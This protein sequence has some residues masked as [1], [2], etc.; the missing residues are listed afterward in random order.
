MNQ[1][2]ILTLSRLPA[3]LDTSQAAALLGFAEH[4]V[5]ILVGA[6]LLK[7]LGNP[8]P[9]GHKYFSSAE[10]QILTADQAWLHKATK[11]VTEHW[12]KKNERQRPTHDHAA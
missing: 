12:R 8:P 3:R 4:D 2:S 5:P 7:P 10:L 9:N 6:K 11:T 1:H